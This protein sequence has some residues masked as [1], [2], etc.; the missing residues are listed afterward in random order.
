MLLFSLNSVL[1][2]R[3]LSVR[4][5]Y[6]FSSLQLR[7]NVCGY[8]VRSLPDLD[9]DLS[10]RLIGFHEVMRLLD[11]FKAEHADRLCA[12]RAFLGFVHHCLKRDT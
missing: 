6:V 5:V 9:D 8:G 4:A 11:L 12:I 10:V 1:K 3:M 7:V 2:P